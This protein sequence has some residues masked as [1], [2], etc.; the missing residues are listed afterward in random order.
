M[1]LSAMVRLHP[2]RRPKRGASPLA[3][4]TA[5]QADPGEFDP[6]APHPGHDGLVALGSLIRSPC[7]VRFA[8]DPPSG[9]SSVWPERSA[10]ARETAGSNPAT[11][12]PLMRCSP[13]GEDTCP[14]RRSRRVRSSRTALCSRRRSPTWQRLR[15]QTASSE[16]SNLS[17]GTN[18]QDAIVVEQAYTAVREAAPERVWGFDSPR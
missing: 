15:A 14:T 6:L 11:Q 10:R 7:C 12:T 4:T 1:N 17:F 18:V 5:L 9:C 3:R 2:Q 16:S 13:S 8:G